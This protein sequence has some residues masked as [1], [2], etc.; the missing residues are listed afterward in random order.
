MN[1]PMII[2]KLMKSLLR[3][4]SE[5]ARRLRQMTALLL[6]ALLALSCLAGC[7]ANSGEKPSKA[8][9]LRG[10][11][12]LG[13]LLGV[14]TKTAGEP[15]SVTAADATGVKIGVS[16]WADDD[17]LSRQTIATIDRAAAL[18]GVEVEYAFCGCDSRRIRRSVSDL[19]AAGCDGILLSNRSDSDIAAAI[20]LCDEKGVYLA[21]LSHWIDEDLY[22]DTY[23]LAKAS[24]YYIG[25]VHGEERTAS[26]RLVNA[27]LEAGDRNIGYITWS[28]SDTTQIQRNIG[29]HM[30]TESF[31]GFH[32]SARIRLADPVEAA[33]AEEGYRVFRQMME[34]NPKLEAVL[35]SGGGGDVL[36]GVLAAVSEMGLIGAIDVAAFDATD[37]M[38]PL[39]TSGAVFAAA[40]GTY[41]QGLYGFLLLLDAVQGNYTKVPGEPGADLTIA[42]LYMYSST[43]GRNYDDSFVLDIPYTDREILELAAL[44]V[45]DLAKAFTALTLTDVLDRHSRETFE[46]PSLSSLLSSDDEEEELSEEEKLEEEQAAAEEAEAEEAKA[47][48]EDLA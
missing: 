28:E 16:L 39:M 35:I 46:F 40:S 38:R 21:Q 8:V 5:P 44:S 43:N 48:V 45:D 7:A 37:S 26:Y 11:R 42:D 47:I 36:D 1:L 15:S 13:D 18:L 30:A 6:T 17:P 29:Y 24:S 12:V 32:K 3:G 31:R 41:C 4:L 10:V 23:A 33:T 34:E 9:D 2:Q 14:E 22:P 19:I 27:L 25:A 20:R